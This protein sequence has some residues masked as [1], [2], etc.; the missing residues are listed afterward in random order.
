M[1]Q[2]HRAKF[3]NR[4][5]NG[6]NYIPLWANGFIDKVLPLLAEECSDDLDKPL[7]VTYNSHVVEIG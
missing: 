5:D 4:L 3:P 1:G 2:G 6:L 7:F